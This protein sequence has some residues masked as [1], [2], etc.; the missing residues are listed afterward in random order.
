V[1]AVV[2]VL[3]CTSDAIATLAR[4]WEVDEVVAG[5][6][7]SAVA[8]G[9]FS[10]RRWRELVQEVSH[11]RKAEDALRRAHD[12]LESRVRDRT[13]ELAR[14]NRE[15]KLEMAERRQ[16]EEKLLTY[17]EQL[18]YLAS[19]LSLAE[20][21]TRRHI[22]V[23][24]HDRIGQALAFCKLRLS[25]LARTARASNGSETLEQVRQL[26]EQ[27][28][29]DARSLTF[30]LSPPVLYELGLEAAVEALAEQLARRHGLHARVEDDGQPKPLPDDLRV[31]LFQAVRELMINVVKHAE[32]SVL[33]VALRRN[34][35][36]LEVRVRDDGRGF[37]PEAVRAG[38]GGNGGFG[39]FS[40][41]E[42]LDVLGG[43]VNVHSAPGEGTSVRLTV[44]VQPVPQ[45]EEIAAP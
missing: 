34:N 28:I 35:G 45:A 10:L 30:E 39:L 5:V 33:D 37:V 21:R 2:F 14:A 20:E 12:Q 4:A 7:I 19:E 22:A 23:G 26:I 29:R 36:H 17:Q 16:A 32:A 3:T 6:T 42:R 44:P 25:Q 8:F 1:A 27:V 18:R 15:L 43:C 24:L 41:R 11:R 40:I 9:V 38:A 31:L 13:A